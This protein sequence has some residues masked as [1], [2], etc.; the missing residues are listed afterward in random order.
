VI[1]Y[2]L[3]RT[4]LA[5][6]TRCRKLN[7]VEAQLTLRGECTIAALRADTAIDD[8]VFILMDV[9][10]GEAELLALDRAGTED[11][12][13]SRRA[14]RKCSCRASRPCSPSVSRQRMI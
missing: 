8:D 13:D 3:D 14:S 4:R 5:L 2:E 10:G 12:R 11:R 6:L 7:R 1:A 9:E